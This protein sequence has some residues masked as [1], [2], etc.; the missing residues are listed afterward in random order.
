MAYT[1]CHAPLE[2]YVRCHHR[3]VIIAT[4][5]LQ[6]GMLDTLAGCYPDDITLKLI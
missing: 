6:T 2:F 4:I 3:S 5:E 1:V